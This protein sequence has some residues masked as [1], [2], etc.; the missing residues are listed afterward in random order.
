MEN[1]NLQPIEKLRPFTKMIM[2][3]GTLPSSFY[4]S[5]SYYESMVWLYEYL[6][7]QV[8]PTVNNNA[9]AVE[10]LQ[11][12]FTELETYIETY[13]DNLDVQEEVNTKLDEMA[14]DGTLQEL[15]SDYLNSKAIFGFDNVSSMINSTNLINGSFARTLGFYNPNDGG[16]SLYKIREINNDDI[17]DNAFIIALKISL[18]SSSLNSSINLYKSLIQLP[19]PISLNFLSNSFLSKF[20]LLI[21][22]I[23]FLS[24]GL[25]NESN[26]FFIFSFKSSI[27][28][29]SNIYSNKL[30]INFN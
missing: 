3:I 17:V 7:N 2:T 5:M 19:K 9:E 14:E 23:I 6:K 8:I 12:K 11:T 22:L 4:A 27:L 13:F 28:S 10:E 24:V 20:I 15:I 1:E 26:L 16:G 29:D 25:S 18:L 30:F 21:I